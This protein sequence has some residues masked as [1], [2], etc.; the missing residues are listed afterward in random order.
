MYESRI[1]ERLA[2]GR[3]EMA[4]ARV[5][6]L[7]VHVKASNPK[8][9]KTVEKAARAEEELRTRIAS[10]VSELKVQSDCIERSRICRLAAKGTHTLDEPV[11]VRKKDRQ[12]GA[13][14]VGG[15]Y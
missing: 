5:K 9:L 12:T 14:I 11:G 15:R 6:M 2:C 4:E 8:Y 3:V 7:E 1:F 10:L 13:D